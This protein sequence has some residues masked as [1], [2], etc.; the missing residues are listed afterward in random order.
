M[1]RKLAALSVV[2]AIAAGIGFCV[3]GDPAPVQSY[4]TVRA[5]YR[6]SEKQPQTTSS[7]PSALHPDPSGRST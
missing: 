4:A 2:V 1:Q 5:D 3:T 6:T 7:R